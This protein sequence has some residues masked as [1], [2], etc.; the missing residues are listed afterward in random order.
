VVATAGA[1]TAQAGYS[2]FYGFPGN[3]TESPPLGAEPSAG[4]TPFDGAFYG[5][6]TRGGS[7]LV[8]GFGGGV[9]L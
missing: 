6:A 3:G 8:N 9:V 2:A 4:L 7:S 1:G 5:T